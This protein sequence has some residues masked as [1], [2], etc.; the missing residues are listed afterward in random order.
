[1][2]N[3]STHAET[4]VSKR[5]KLEARTILVKIQY[6]TAADLKTLNWLTADILATN[7]IENV[8]HTR[9]VYS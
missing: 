2:K 8:K 5:G 3:I 1:M 9:A 4:C 6:T 7:V